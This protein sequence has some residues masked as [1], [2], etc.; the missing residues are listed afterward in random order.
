MEIIEVTCEEY[1]RVIPYPYFIYGLSPFNILNRDKCEKVHFL[2]FREGKFRLGIVIGVKSNSLFSPF[3]APFGGFTFISQEIRIQYIEEAILKL[4]DW[5]SLNEYESVNITL[6]PDLY[7]NSFISKQINCLWR[8]GFSINKIEL[9]YAF[10]LNKFDSSYTEIIWRNARKNLNIAKNA[11]LSI[12]LCE[13]KNDKI[14]AYD[15][16]KKNREQ[17]GFPLRMEWKEIEETTMI[18]RSDFFIIQNKH[19]NDIASAIIFY[20][21]EYVVQVIY[22]GDLLE[23]SSLKPMNFLSY[24]LFEFYKKNGVTFVDIGPSTENSIPNYGLGEFKESIGCTIQPKYSFSK[25][26]RLCLS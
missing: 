13:E 10:N 3:S 17:K 5:A 6:P 8:G 21:S 23:Y 9:N 22:W 11:G 14:R 20:V 18:I 26:L 16:I 4:S 2:L 1:S 19:F 24:K 7:E 15:I 25:D 12:V